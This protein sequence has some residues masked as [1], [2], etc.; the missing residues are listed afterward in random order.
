MSKKAKSKALGIVALVAVIGFSMAGCPTDTPEPTVTGVEISPVTATV[1]RGDTWDFAA[2]VQGTNDPPQTVT[3]AVVGGVSGTSISDAGRLAV[4]AN[5]TAASLMVRAS[6]TLN[7]AVSGSV[8]VT[9]TAPTVTIPGTFTVTYNGNGN[10]GGTVPTEPNSPFAG[11][12]TVTVMGVGNLV[13]SGHTFMG[14]NTQA[15]GGG[16]TRVPGETFVISANTTLYAQWLRM[17]FGIQLSGGGVDIT[18]VTFYLPDAT[19]GY[20]QQA[21]QTIT[22]T[23]TS[24]QDTGPLTV[25]SGDSGASF[26]LPLSIGSIAAGASA[27]FMISPNT[28]LPAGTHSTIVTVSGGHGITAG[29]TASFR[30]HPAFIYSA[31]ITVASP[32]TGATPVGKASGTGYFTVGAVSWNPSHNPFLGGTYTA[33]LTLTANADFIFSDLFEGIISGQA[34]TVTNNTGAVVTLSR[35]FVARHGSG[36]FV[37]VEGGTFQMGCLTTCCCSS[38]VRAVTVSGFCMSRFQVTQGEWYDV[39]GTRPSRFTGATNWDGVPVTGVNWRNLPVESVSW[40]EALVFSNRLSIR[41]GLTPAY[42]INGSTNPDDWG[43]VPWLG[44]PIWDA[45]EI[46]PGSTGY[47]LPTEAQWEFA[48]RGGIVCHGNFVFSGSDT[49]GD[50]AWIWEN[51]DGRTHEVGTRQPNALGLYDMSGNV[52]EWVW[53]WWG[54]YPDYPETDPVGA[55]SGSVR[56]RRGGCWVSPARSGARSFRAGEDPAM[57]GDDLGFRLVRP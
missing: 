20:G 39:M 23:N 40:Y 11:G 9:V 47:R 43:S 3:W 19:S 27:S 10:T 36:S 54:S 33:M 46:V 44:D 14:W 38:P 49:V 26:E 4:A 21:A 16:T 29:F 25:S 2:V 35:S 30:V 34:A 51:S 7:P 15:D 41:S 8:A 31:A 28:G 6:S 5:E 45:V 55:F 52:W 32:V 37:R 17:A 48:A 56:V 18:G 57:G 12:A 1:E 42:R 13:K 22:V 53:D 24:N 50:V